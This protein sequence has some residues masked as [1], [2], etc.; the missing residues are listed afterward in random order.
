[1]RGTGRSLERRGSAGASGAMAVPTWALLPFGCD[2]RW[3]TEGT[4][5]PWYPTMRLFRQPALHDWA[6]VIDAVSRAIDQE[7]A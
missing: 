4:T 5:S 1:M 3:M 6:G 7:L 2:Y